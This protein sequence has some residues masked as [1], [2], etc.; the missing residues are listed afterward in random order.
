MT[1]DPASPPRERRFRI[2]VDYWN[3]QL[4]F[5]E[6]HAHKTGEKNPR[7]K[8][9]WPKMG[10][11]LAAEAAKLPGLAPY[12]YEGTSIYTSFNPKTDEGKKFNNWVNT[13]MNRQPGVNVYCLERQAKH[14]PVCPTCHKRVETC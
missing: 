4:S 13:F 6:N 3:F 2:F 5:N 12:S 11:I 9:N 14:P 10:E 7:L 1:S 8:I